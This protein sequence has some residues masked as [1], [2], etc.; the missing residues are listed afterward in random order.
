MSAALVI[1][2]DP[3]AAAHVA[4]GIARTQAKRRRV[5]I[6]DLV[7]ELEPLQSLVRGGDEVHGITD[8]FLYGASLNKIAQPVG[9]SGNLF[10]MPSGTEPVADAEIY[11]SDRWR[12][13]AAGFGSEK[14]LL[15]LVAPA[16]ATGVDTLASMLDGVVTVG[17]VAARM[18]MQQHIV[19][20]ASAAPAPPRKPEPRSGPS[21]ARQRHLMREEERASAARWA[22]PAVIA[23]A[24]LAGGAWWWS[25]RAPAEPDDAPSGPA[26]ATAP[27]LLDAPPPSDGPRDTLRIGT[28]VNPAD[29]ARSSAFAVELRALNTPQG[30]ALSLREE[31][32]TLPAA[33]YAPVLLDSLSDRWFMVIAGA[34]PDRRGADSLL[35]ATRSR[36][37]LGPTGGRVIRVPYALQLREGV[38][39]DSAAAAVALWRERSIPAYALLQRDGTATLYAGAFETSYQAGLLASS[40]RAAGAAPVL[41]FRTGSVF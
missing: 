6:G 15:L 17:E 26:P 34:Y 21:L 7:G 37:V 12:R 30:A 13:L 20:L 33:T 22:L 39:R 2:D 9:E 23:G 32:A 16:G 29:S 10:V 11:R 36:R 40:L 5:A 14:A 19:V 8:S 3:A 27:S 41:A 25:G 38:P 24:V 18:A 35:A 1:G 4:L 31:G 28:P